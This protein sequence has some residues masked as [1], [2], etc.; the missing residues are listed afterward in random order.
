MLAPTSEQ[1]E[2][3]VRQRGPY[4]EALRSIGAFLDNRHAFHANVIE[5]LD[6]FTVR[7]QRS[8]LHSELISEHL[9]YVQLQAPADIKHRRRGLP[10]GGRKPERRYEDILRA[11]G[12]ELD[13][14]QAYSLLIDEIDEGFLVTYQYLKPSQGV[15]VRKRMV[16]LDSN[17]VV[18]VL[19]DAH[20]R[21]INDK[22]TEGR[23]SIRTV[24]AG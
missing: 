15:M 22:P 13:E 6:G 20:G 16:F 12:F 5:V 7:Y 19:D 14:A 1:W 18:Q 4:Q 3:L 9:G 10:F 24:L 17:S 2:S 21:R 8:D 23:R 11:L